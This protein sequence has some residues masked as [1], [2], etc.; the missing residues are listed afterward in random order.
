MQQSY[1]ILN[2]AEI[3]RCRKAQIHGYNSIFTRLD[4]IPDSKLFFCIRE[5]QKFMNFIMK[6]YYFN[7]VNKINEAPVNKKWEA[8]IF[9]GKNCELLY[10]D[11]EYESWTLG[12]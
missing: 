11:S 3:C 2:F 1:L 7:P 6:V 9:M 4:L 8:P 12:K 5:A 10:F